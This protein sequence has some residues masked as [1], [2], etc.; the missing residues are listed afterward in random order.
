MATR[1]EQEQRIQRLLDKLDRS[2]TISQ[3]DLRTAIGPQAKDEFNA[4]WQAEIDQRDYFAN[5]PVEL[6]D[7][8][9]LLKDADFRNNRAEAMPSPGKRSKLNAQGH[10][11]KQRLAADAERTYEIALETLNVLLE[12]DPSLRTWLDRPVRWGLAHGP[13]PNAE[14][15]PRLVTS[16]SIHKQTKSGHSSRSKADIKRSML[17]DAL[18]DQTSGENEAPDMGQLESRLRRSRSLQ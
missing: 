3:R 15:V 10:N 11:S 2:E 4:L 12:R 5:V 1:T 17:K 9:E 16:K 8:E 14:D 13:T 7:Y 6:H 18:S